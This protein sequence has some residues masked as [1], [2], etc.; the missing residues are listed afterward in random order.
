MRTLVKAALVASS[1]VV[2]LPVHADFVSSSSYV[3]KAL[4]EIC[5]EAKADDVIGL[6]NTL[7]SYNISKKNAAQKVMCNQQWLVSFA[8]THQA[9]RIVSMLER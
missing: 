6:N 5:N 1:L 2:V 9:Y 4:V 8:R 7:D 3:Q